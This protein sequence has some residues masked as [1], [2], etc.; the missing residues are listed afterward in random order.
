MDLLKNK[1]DGYIG[2]RKDQ[3]TYYYESTSFGSA[4]KI[5][6]YFDKFHLLSSKY[7]SYLKWRKAYILIQNRDHLT[8]KG[9]KKIIKLKNTMNKF[10]KKIVD[11][12]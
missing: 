9:I 3:D 7:I 1:F 11:L 5:I 10:N 4:K 12:N 2:H 6:T 8:E